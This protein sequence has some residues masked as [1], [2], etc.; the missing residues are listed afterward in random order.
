M[1]SQEAAARHNGLSRLQ[2]HRCPHCVSAAW[3]WSCGGAELGKSW[4]AAPQVPSLPLKE[5]H[6]EE[7]RLLGKSTVCTDFLGAVALRGQDLAGPGI[8]PAHGRGTCNSEGF[9]PLFS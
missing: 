3:G 2:S 4:G 6:G 7:E 1:C 9:A 5:W 8:F